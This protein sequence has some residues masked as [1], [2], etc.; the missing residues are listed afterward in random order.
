MTPDTY[1][2]SK[3]LLLKETPISGKIEGFSTQYSDKL[4]LCMQL[5]LVHVVH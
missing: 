1:S 5:K 3:P 4:S 2:Y